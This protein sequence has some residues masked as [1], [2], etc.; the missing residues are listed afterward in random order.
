M[1]RLE[2]PAVGVVGLVAAN[3]GLVF[4]YFCY[5]LGFVPLPAAVAAALAV[6]R[7]LPACLDATAFAVLLIGLKLFADRRL[8]AAE[9]HDMRL[10]ARAAAARAR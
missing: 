4:L 7:F 9:R 1:K 5:D 3:A 2:H 6:A 10:S 8:H